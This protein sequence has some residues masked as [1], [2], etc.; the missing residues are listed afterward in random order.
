MKESITMTAETA[1]GLALW[2]SL[3]KE[4]R[5]QMLALMREM[6]ANQE[7]VRADDTKGDAE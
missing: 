1:L 4:E 7:R 5:E 6:I 3:G 2:E